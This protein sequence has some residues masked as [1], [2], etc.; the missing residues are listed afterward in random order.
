[1]R[2]IN[3]FLI[4]AAGWCAAAIPAVAQSDLR[5]LRTAEYRALQRRL[6]RGWNTWS[7]NS[8]MAHVHLP[9]GFALTLGVK[10][11][12]LGRTYQDSFFQANQTAGR[13]EKIRLGAHSDDGSYTE[14]T[15][16]LE[17]NGNQSSKNVV[18]V[19]SAEQDGEDYI[20]VTVE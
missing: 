15:L 6:C 12:G 13:P 17:T 9:D 18:R 16:E 14:L 7:A 8:V 4:A 19:E 20:L 3:L 1:M 10:S 5:V 11:A 2:H